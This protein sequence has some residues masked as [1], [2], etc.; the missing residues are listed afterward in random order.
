MAIKP[1]PP[2]SAVPQPGLGPAAAATTE[3]LDK[4]AAA[5]AQATRPQGEVFAE[6]D[7]RPPPAPEGFLAA[8]QMAERA[9]WKGQMERPVRAQ[10]LD[11]LGGLTAA[12][13]LALVAAWWEEMKA[14]APRPDQLSFDTHCEQHWGELADKLRGL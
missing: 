13:A 7:R 10:T 2:K 11:T 6:P 9:A 5:I 14:T 1:L 4:V 12:R 8:H 3:S